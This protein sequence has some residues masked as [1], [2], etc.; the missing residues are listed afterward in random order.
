MLNLNLNRRARQKPAQRLSEGL[1]GESGRVPLRGASTG[2]KSL[3]SGDLTAKVIFPSALTTYGNQVLRVATSSGL[4]SRRRGTHILEG[5]G[6][7]SEPR[8]W[9]THLVKET[10][11][12]AEPPPGPFSCGLIRGKSGD[13]RNGAFPHRWASPTTVRLRTPL[14]LPCGSLRGAEFGTS[15]EWR[16][17]WSL[18]F[19][20][21]TLR[22]GSARH[23]STQ[24]PGL[25]FEP[26]R[27][28]SD[29]EGQNP[30]VG[31]VGG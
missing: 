31:R 28:L 14:P 6:R 13:L 23:P 16:S 9:R 2:S 8:P 25:G 20:H 30:T 26:R 17:Y 22:P 12:Q 29:Q 7:G 3:L 15:A 24:P 19:A 11:D 10:K 18:G 27:S 4:A 21:P 1:S 5:H